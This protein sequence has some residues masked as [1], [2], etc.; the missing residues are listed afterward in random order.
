V[1]SGALDALGTE[2]LVLDENNMEKNFMDLCIDNIKEVP[3]KLL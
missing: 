1:D 2:L 3:L